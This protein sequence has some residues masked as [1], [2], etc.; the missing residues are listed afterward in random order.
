MAIKSAIFN[1]WK[2]WSLTFSHTPLLVFT[3]I[4]ITFSSD[5]R[6]PCWITGKSL[7]PKSK[8]CPVLENNHTHT[9]TH[10]YIYIYIRS[11]RMRSLHIHRKNS[12]CQYL[13]ALYT[14]SASM[15][16]HCFTLEAKDW[17]Y[18]ALDDA[19]SRIPSTEGLWQDKW[20]KDRNF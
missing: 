14:Y 2:L 15:L 18:K 20:K 1:Y 9:H 8:K 19:I 10:T 16:Q 5:L 7:S 12:T 17:F 3:I 13:V 4:G 6:K 11:N